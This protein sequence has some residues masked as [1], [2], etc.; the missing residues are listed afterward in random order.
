MTARNTVYSRVDL[1]AYTMGI[2]I[3]GLMAGILITIVSL[4]EPIQHGT[5]KDQVDY[6]KFTEPK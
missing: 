2:F 3:A 5:H 4:S 1:A 6:K